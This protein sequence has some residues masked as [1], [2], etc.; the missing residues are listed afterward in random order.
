MFSFGRNKK[1][2]ENNENIEELEKI[3]QTLDQDGNGRIRVVDLEAALQRFD[4]DNRSKSERKNQV[5][6][7][8]KSL[9]PKGDRIDGQR[10]LQIMLERQ[11]QLKLR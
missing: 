10:F 4:D 9:K 6:K 2:N 5:K 3:V 11:K 7:F 1:T 8:I